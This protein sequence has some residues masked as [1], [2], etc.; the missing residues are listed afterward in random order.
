MDF[1]E[2]ARIRLDH[3]ITHSDDHQEEYA[4]FAGQLEAAGKIESAKYIKELIDLSSRS[5]E[6]LRKALAALE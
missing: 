2:K 1:S 6:C 3:W 5:T 4:M